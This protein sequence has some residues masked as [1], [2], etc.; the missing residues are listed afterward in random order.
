MRMTCVRTA[1][2]GVMFT[3][4]VAAAASAQTMENVN[5][6]PDTIAEKGR[7]RRS[8]ERRIELAAR[9]ATNAVAPA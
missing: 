6:F 9:G 1:I 8:A 2:G 3:V 5:Y 4:G 7:S